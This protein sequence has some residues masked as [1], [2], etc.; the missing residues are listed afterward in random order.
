VL[1]CDPDRFARCP[2]AV[3]QQEADG[4]AGVRTGSALV[5]EFG[6]ES[7]EQRLD[8]LRA[9]REHGVRMVRLGHTTAVLGGRTDLVAL[10]DRHALEVVSQHPGREQAGEATPDNQGV[11]PAISSLLGHVGS[12]SRR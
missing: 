7:G 12:S 9:A 1:R 6:E 10:H 11:G 4:G 3:R 8:L 2:A 5:G